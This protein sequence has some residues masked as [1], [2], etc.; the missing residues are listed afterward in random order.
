MTKI[1]ITIALCFALNGFAQNRPYM[2]KIKSLKVAFI[3]EQ[4]NLAPEEAQA[5]WPVY[6]A[7]EEQMNTFRRLERREIRGPLRNMES[8]KD[9][10]AEALVDKLI[11]LEK[12]K[13]QEQE[14]F[15]GQMRKIIPAKKV[16]LLMKSEEDFKRKLIQQYRDNRGG[17]P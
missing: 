16:L 12:E 10:E 15:L 4:L 17:K 14:A 7:H 13:Q 11:A 3:T 6:N 9:T 1:M 8:L 5:F 2:E